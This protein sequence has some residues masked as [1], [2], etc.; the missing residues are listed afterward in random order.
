MEQAP[1]NYHLQ[2]RHPNGVAFR[3]GHHPSRP[4]GLLTDLRSSEQFCQELTRREARNFYWGFMALPKAERTATYALYAFAREVDDEVDLYHVRHDMNN[5]DEARAAITRR[6]N[7]HR[8]RVNDCFN[9]LATDPVMHVLSHVVHD[10][11]MVEEEF[12]ALIDGVEMDID[13]SRYAT[14]EDFRRYCFHVASTIGRMCV[15]VWGFSDPVALDYAVD[16]GVAM[17]LTNA[18]RDIHEDYEIGRV[19]LPQE[20]LD[21]FGIQESAIADGEDVPGWTDLMNFE[22]E[23]AHQLFDSGLRVTGF[24]PRRSRVCVYTM[25]GIYQGLLKELAADP[26]IPLNRRASLGGRAKA[27]IMMTS[28]LRAW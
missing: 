7:H 12:M 9:G 14:W 23:R 25:A 5:H 8:A 13:T 4:D 11:A 28:W 1:S 27:S 26:T 20:D 21:R 17:Q 15:R 10:H 3:D 6:L 18:L 16:L 19:Y 2:H 24:I 22:I